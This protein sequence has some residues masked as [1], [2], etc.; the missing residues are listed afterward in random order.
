MLIPDTANLAC[1]NWPPATW[2][3]IVKRPLPCSVLVVL[4]RQ[5]GGSILSKGNLLPCTRS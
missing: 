1:P 3:V 5:S 4:S 2:T